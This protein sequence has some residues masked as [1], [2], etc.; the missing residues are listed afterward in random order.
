MAVFNR[1]PLEAAPDGGP[2]EESKPAVQSDR[3]HHRFDQLRD[4][5]M[6]GDFRARPTTP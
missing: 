3:T 2:L 4:E 5:H 6:P 1:S